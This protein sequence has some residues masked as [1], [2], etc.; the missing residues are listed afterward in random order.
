[1]SETNTCESAFPRPYS[2]P[3]GFNGH[4]VYT[5]TE[6]ITIRDYFAAKA[7]QA[8]LIKTHDQIEDEKTIA[9]TA[10]MYADAMIVERGK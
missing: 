5:A 1:M 2:E 3:R 10:Y 6:G 7:L 4:S 9:A 8:L